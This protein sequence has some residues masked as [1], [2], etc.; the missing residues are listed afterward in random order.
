L[1]RRI[2]K[3]CPI[4]PRKIREDGASENPD[5]RKDAQI[6]QLKNRLDIER[7]RNRTEKDIAKGLR[8]KMKSLSAREV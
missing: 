1:L 6:L 4:A 3:S 2:P 5:D 8:D 7:Q